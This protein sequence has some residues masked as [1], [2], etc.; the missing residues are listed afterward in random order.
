M[1]YATN[2]KVLNASDFGIPQNRERLFTVSVLGDSLFEFPKGT[3]T[4]RKIMDVME[5]DPQPD[6]ILSDRVVENYE[7]CKTDQHSKGRGFG[8]CP[9]TP[10][11]IANT[12]NTSPS[13]NSTSTIIIAGDLNHKSY[14]ES[15]NRVYS[16]DG[17][18]PTVCTRSGGGNMA[19]IETD[20]QIRYLTER[21]CFR[22]M[23]VPENDIDAIF[24][25]IQS[26]TARYKLAGN[27][28][29]VSVLVEIFRNLLIETPTVQQKTLF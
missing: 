5:T 23:D 26:K 27:S 24:S 28:I 10:N 15:T 9:K 2:C 22:L 14:Y 1:G 18:S 8:G 13:K 3:P 25:V 11:E 16:I 19:K 17:L 7:K 6:Y 21:E 12:V 29:V 4:D 20:Q